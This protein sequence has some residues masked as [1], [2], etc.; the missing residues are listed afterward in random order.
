MFFLTYLFFPCFSSK[1][2]KSNFHKIPTKL[3]AVL[4]VGAIAQAEEGMYS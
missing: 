1:K 2:M 4:K 3:A